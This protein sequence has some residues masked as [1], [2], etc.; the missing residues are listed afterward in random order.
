[1]RVIPGVKSVE[2]DFNIMIV[3]YDEEIV[4]AEKIIERAAS[5]SSRQP[6]VL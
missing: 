4:K 5:G 1:V 2:F 3:E 6:E